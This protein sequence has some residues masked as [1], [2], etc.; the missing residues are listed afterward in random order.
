VSSWSA[1]RPTPRRG[2]RCDS[3][4]AREGVAGCALTLQD[5]GD[6]VV[7]AAARA[8][9]LVLHDVRDAET[10]ERA[11]V[12]RHDRAVNPSLLRR[13]SPDDATRPA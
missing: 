1:A 10:G 2:A 13:P 4:A 5:D 11:G 6:L 12:E 8:A 3:A 7:R 9:V